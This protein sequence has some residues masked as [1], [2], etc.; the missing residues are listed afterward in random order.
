MISE[1][2]SLELS[3][4]VKSGELFP[5]EWSP[6]D[7]KSSDV[8][9]AGS[10]SRTSASWGRPE[11]DCRGPRAF[12]SDDQP[13]AATQ[14][15]EGQLLCRPSSAAS[16]AAAAGASSVPQDGRSQ[17]NE[18]VRTC[19]TQEWSPEQIAGRLEQEHPK[20]PQRRVSAQTIYT[21]IERD[22]HRLHWRS[23]LRHRGKRRC[24]RKKARET[25]L[26]ARIHNRPEIIE[27]RLQ[28]GDFEGDPGAPGLGPPGVFRQQVVPAA[29]TKFNLFTAGSPQPRVASNSSGTGV[30]SPCGKRNSNCCDRGTGDR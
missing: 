3:K 25:G 16:G 13:Q 14:R 11:G 22:Q 15:R 24:R 30:D 17:L 21:W 9:R 20:S 12:P 6:R 19:L 28:L 29:G 26:G 27:R 1:K 8:G 18:A 10:H 23:F 5:W 7:G 4:W 2:T